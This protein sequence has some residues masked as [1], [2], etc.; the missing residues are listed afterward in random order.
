MNRRR[1]HRATFLVAGVYNILWGLLSALYPVWFFQFAGMEPPRY[2]EIFSCLGMVIGLYGILYLRI[3]LEPESGF[4]L[5]LVGL[6]GKVL[7]PIGLMVLLL[8]GK[9]PLRSAVLI[10]TNDLV[11][12]VPFALYLL[13]VRR[14]G[15]AARPD[16][17]AAR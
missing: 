8:Q 6:T 15:A 17:N 2:P 13:D 11:W 5:A 14:A 10:V 16:M 9:W 3:A 1:L 4:W 7:G 12:W